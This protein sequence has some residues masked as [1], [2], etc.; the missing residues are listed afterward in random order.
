[1]QLASLRNIALEILDPIRIRNI[2]SILFAYHNYRNKEL[3]TATYY[4][5]RGNVPCN[6]INVFHFTAIPYASQSLMFIGMNRNYCVLW[7]P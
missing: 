5:A 7:K 3:Y 2:P 4:G 1:M 6:V